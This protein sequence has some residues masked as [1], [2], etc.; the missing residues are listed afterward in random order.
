[1]ELT[2]NLKQGLLFIGKWEWGNRPDGGYTNDPRDPGG[3][4]K[5]GISKRAHPTVDIKNLT[6]EQATEIYRKEYWTPAGCDSIPFPN[7]VAVF[8]TAVNCG[9]GRATKWLKVTS[10]IQAFLEQRMIHY[11]TIAKDNPNLKAYVGGWTNRVN[12]LKKYLEINN[13]SI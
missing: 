7:C 11:L 10:T 8:D 1:M 9:V 4:T 6:L 3:E 13:S 5:F 2:N 12:D